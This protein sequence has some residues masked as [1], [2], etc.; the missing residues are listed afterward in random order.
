MRIEI[1]PSAGTPIYLQIVNQVKYLVASGQL[2]PEEEIPPIRVLAEQ[3]VINPNTVAR[4]YL[5]LERAGI[6]LKKQGSG[7]FVAESP[8]SVGRRQRQKILTERVDALLTEAKQLG[9]EMDELL[10]L[11]HSR[12]ERMTPANR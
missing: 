2:V 5:E 4:A 6:V 8:P 1:Q 11:L 9:V 12:Q 7:T 3:L 10:E